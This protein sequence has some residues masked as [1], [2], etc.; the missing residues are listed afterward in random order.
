MG[1]A[2]YG[3]P[4]YMREMPELVRLH[5]GYELNLEY[6]CHHREAIS[7]QWMSGSLEFGDLFSSALGELLGPRRR[8]EDPLLDR[9]RNFARSVPSTRLRAVGRR[10]C[11]WCHGRNIRFSWRRT[12]LHRGPRY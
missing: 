5:D 6:F 1:L 8:P 10:G 7:Y 2:F 9:H 11:R 3:T 4:S 12:I